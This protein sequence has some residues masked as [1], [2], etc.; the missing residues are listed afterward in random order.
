MIDKTKRYKTRSGFPVCVTSIHDGL[1]FP[2]HGLVELPEG[3]ELPTVWTLNGYY[4]YSGTLHDHDLIEV[5]QETEMNKP[6]SNSMNT[7][8]LGVHGNIPVRPYLMAFTNIDVEQS[9]SI[10][11]FADVYKDLFK[12]IYSKEPDQDETTGLRIY[13]PQFLQQYYELVCDMVQERMFN[14]AFPSK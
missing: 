3:N 13:P 6:L 11:I 1:N 7:I 12:S 9:G 10:R 8:T 14:S 5:V 2:V 4:Y